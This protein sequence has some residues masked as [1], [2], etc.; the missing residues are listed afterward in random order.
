MDARSLARLYAV[1]ATGGEVDGVRL[2]VGGLDRRVE[3]APSRQNDR[4]DGR[5]FRIALGYIKA[6]SW[7]RDGTDR[8]HVR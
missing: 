6:S 7:Y 5:D 3:H 2:A 1:L 8:R 4:Y